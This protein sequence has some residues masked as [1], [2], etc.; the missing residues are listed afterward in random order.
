MSDFAGWPQAALTFFEGLEADNSKSYWTSHKDVYDVAVRAPMETLVAELGGEFG[1]ATLFRPHR[2]VRFSADK[3][4]YKTQVA[5]V[6]GDTGSGAFYVQLSADGLMTG[7][8][9]HVMTPGQVA[10]LRGAIDDDRSGTALGAI[11]SSLVGSGFEVGGDA[12][13]TAPRGYPR[14]H[15]RIELLRY[16]SCFV[17][18]PHPPAT[19]LHAARAADV[20]RADWRSA[21]P[22]VDWL[23]AHVGPGEAVSRG[24]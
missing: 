5:A 23:H 21:R 8:G 13:K 18:R 24:R 17:L 20:V 9:L 22:L 15:P 4:P 7:A 6:L 19:W 3:S 14:D 2:D 16:R 12:L 10:R 1:P 11:V